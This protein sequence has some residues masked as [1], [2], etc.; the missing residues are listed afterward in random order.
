M[1]LYVIRHGA[2]EPSSP[3]GDFGRHLTEEGRRMLM[4]TTFGLARMGVRFDHLLH[5]PM[6]R[7]AETATTLDALVNETP[8]ELAGLAAPPDEALLA[9]V[10]KLEGIVAVV[11][12]LPWVGELASWLT[13]GRPLESGTFI[14][15]PGAIAALDG[16]LEPGGM[17]IS[18]FWQPGDL[19]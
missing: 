19:C 15:S 4:A 1:M 11:G 13:T 18:G 2:A 10:R 12:H 5:S 14:F 7:A 8:V 16:E 6:V 17:R 3:N 9:E